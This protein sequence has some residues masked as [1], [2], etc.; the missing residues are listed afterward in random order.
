MSHPTADQQ[1]IYEDWVAALACPDVDCAVVAGLESRA[2]EVQLD[3]LGSLE[4][5]ILRATGQPLTAAVKRSWNPDLHPRGRDGRFIEKMGFVKFLFDLARDSSEGIKSAGSDSGYMRGQVTDIVPDPKAPGKPDI[6][7][8][9]DTPEGPKILT[10][11]PGE[12][13]TA[14]RTKAT[15]TLTPSASKKVDPDADR[16][17]RLEAMSRRGGNASVKSGQL[18]E[19]HAP[20]VE[21]ARQRDEDGTLGELTDD[22]LDQM[23]S[24]TRRMAEV[25][26]EDGYEDYTPEELKAIDDAVLDEVEERLATLGQDS[27][28]VDEVDLN[29]DSD[30]E[31]L[32][33]PDPDLDDDDGSLDETSSDSSGDVDRPFVPLPPDGDDGAVPLRDQGD[34]PF[35]PDPTDEAE[36]VV[37]PGEL[38]QLLTANEGALS[39]DD[40]GFG[41]VQTMGYTF[42]WKKDGSGDARV[43][44]IDDENDD[45]IDGTVTQQAIDDAQVERVA[46]VDVTTAQTSVDGDHVKSIIE[47]PDDDVADTSHSQEPVV[48]R[49]D[50][51]LYM[52]DGHH[53]AVADAASTGDGS[54]NARVVDMDVD[55][56]EDNVPAPPTDVSEMLPSDDDGADTDVIDAAPDDEDW[57]AQDVE[58]IVDNVSDESW[59]LSTLNTA[60]LETMRE[61]VKRLVDASDE[62]ESPE[63]TTLEMIDAQLVGLESDSSG[64]SIVFDLARQLEEGDLDLSAYGLDQLM[65]L[66]EEAADAVADAPSSSP[67]KILF[68][69]L[70]DALDDSIV[71]GQQALDDEYE[72]DFNA[73]DVGASGRSES[74]SSTDASTSGTLTP[75]FNSDPDGKTGEGIIAD[76]NGDVIGYVVQTD[77]GSFETLDDQ[78]QP[79]G[80]VFTEPDEAGQ[81][82][83]ADDTREAGPGEYDDT[84]DVDL[85]GPGGQEYEY[86]DLED[87]FMAAEED[88]DGWADQISTEE[89]IKMRDGI[90]ALDTETIGDEEYADMQVLRSTLD[91]ELQTREGG[92]EDD[93]TDLEPALDLSTYDDSGLD[94]A[95]VDSQLDQLQAN[96]ESDDP[97]WLEQEYENYAASID[98][99]LL[100]EITKSEDSADL[101]PIFVEAA[102]ME[103]QSRQ[104][105]AP[106]AETDAVDTNTDDETLTPESTSAAPTPELP[107]ADNDWT[108]GE[109]PYGDGANQETA[110]TMPISALPVGSEIWF[111]GKK[112]KVGKPQD[113]GDGDVVSK[114]WDGQQWDYV[115]PETEFKVAT[116]PD[117]KP[118]DKV[119]RDYLDQ[120]GAVV[121]APSSNPDLEGDGVSGP[122]EPGS[123]F[124]DPD[125]VDL[126][127]TGLENATGISQLEKATR[128]YDYL[129][130][131]D[132]EWTS[133]HTEALAQKYGLGSV[134]SSDLMTHVQESTMGTSA[135]L[136]PDVDAPSVD[137]LD[138]NVDL[139]SP[140]PPTA[141]MS[142]NVL[143][144]ALDGT[145]LKVGTPVT[146]IKDGFEGTVTGMPDQEK[147]PGYVYIEPVEGGKKKLRSVKTLKTPGKQAA[148]TSGPAVNAATDPTPVS[149]DPTPETTAPDV[150]LPDSPQTSSALDL[151]DQAGS[152]SGFNMKA[153]VDQVRDR[154]KSPDTV[155]KIKFIDQLLMTD[156]S[157][158][159]HDKREQ[160]RNA[161]KQVKAEA[162]E[163]A[164]D[165]KHRI[166]MDLIDSENPGYSAISVLG[167][168]RDE[169]DRDFP[170]WRQNGIP[171]G[172]SIMIA[173]PGGYET[174]V[175][176]ADAQA[177][178]LGSEAGIV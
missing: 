123:L 178:V 127:D 176:A 54:F 3:L 44:L 74:A 159:P 28:G 91:Q 149:P 73:D 15:L 38:M 76:D 102:R 53:R 162:A 135:P 30:D 138:E 87:L 140:V 144:H 155:K 151:L 115:Q 35:V 171:A 109:F 119:M 128:E 9:V 85:T 88:P 118:I 78:G 150:S 122:N 21:E 132:G 126:A 129:S 165:A 42:T 12:L 60:Q 71:Y 67:D 142:P 168:L 75:G 24:A 5:D 130:S 68:S 137:D 153:Q 1:R 98:D 7:I 158:M 156:L 136:E 106:N 96:P 104:A 4:D 166:D 43:S 33:A 59:D 101:D 48:F 125:S 174:S 25:H 84:E 72:P 173:P 110:P 52:G 105:A 56:D 177:L 163:A 16:L 41:D 63:R 32:V 47:N 148:G 11:K 175:S 77:E 23:N 95:D 51:K 99:T 39:T 139:G 113:N 80:N 49:H 143:A 141:E 90:D 152:V 81:S 172:A 45:V 70:Y 26:S 86:D 2:V 36:D 37:P 97:E 57:S 13:D 89:L 20:L 34:V 22:E 14:P 58:T 10:R 100:A 124:V 82:L 160:L 133:S 120:P 61:K 108:P 164:S 161:L 62:T 40:V 103:L 69:A 18:D 147:Y 8:K 154:L 79:T 121:D 145:E 31:T 170:G 167:S 6:K 64:A 94:L 92:D 131:Q 93:G 107:S 27:E 50:G 29:P 169:L 157:F 65:G 19:R 83:I 114:W 134:E 17:E 66:K 117:G 116:V 111:Q 46:L 55:V 112:Y 146:S